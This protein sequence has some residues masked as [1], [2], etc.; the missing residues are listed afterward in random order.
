[1]QFFWYVVQ[2]T[3]WQVTLCSSSFANTWV[4]SLV[5]SLETKTGGA[6]RSWGEAA[7]LC[8]V[9]TAEEAITGAL[10]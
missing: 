5:I 7:V 6:G 8:K 1:M 4:L 2:R 9:A 3:S 10:G